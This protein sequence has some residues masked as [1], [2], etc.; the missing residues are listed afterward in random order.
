MEIC[1]EG[2]QKSRIESTTSYLAI[3]FYTRRTLYPTT[4]ILP[5]PRSPLLIHNSLGI[6]VQCSMITQ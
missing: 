5:H 4:D 3:A 2:S 6:Y 1:V